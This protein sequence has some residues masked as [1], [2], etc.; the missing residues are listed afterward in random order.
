MANTVKVTLHGDSIYSAEGVTL[1]PGDNQVEQR[2]LDK[3][4]KNKIVRARM[5]A[6]KFT[7]EG[8]A[9]GDK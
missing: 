8:E 7:V 5:D 6:G 9:K 3:F 4:L 1:F 2:Q